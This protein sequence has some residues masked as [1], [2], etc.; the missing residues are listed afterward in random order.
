MGKY[1]KYMGIA[2]A[3]QGLLK[4][5]EIKR[6]D[7]R[8]E[9]DLRREKWMMEARF[10]H[11]RN[12][13]ETQ[14]TDRERV[15]QEQAAAAAAAAE[16]DRLKDEATAQQKLA[17]E[18]YEISHG[19]TRDWE[20]ATAPENQDRWLQRELEQQRARAAA[21]AGGTVAGRAGE[22]QARGIGEYA[23]TE[24]G[25]GREGIDPF[26]KDG[27]D[28]T[29]PEVDLITT[30]QTVQVFGRKMGYMEGMF[31]TADIQRKLS[32][33]NEE[34]LA[35]LGRAKNTY[36][37]MRST[38]LEGLTQNPPTDRA[39]ANEEIRTI[40]DELNGWLPELAFRDVYNV[41]NQYRRMGA[42]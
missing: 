17:D 34:A 14:L 9:S 26:S 25:G 3:F 19:A 35:D 39:Q 42:Q 32:D 38:L 2:G 31:M 28:V 23:P 30:G 33:G 4:A 13:L 21:Q 37:R 40:R 12:M 15:R 11:D 29:L 41:L 18:A 36:N 1:A 24:G 10:Q 7:E 5:S 8:R 6:E 16:E 20:E 22:E 27:A